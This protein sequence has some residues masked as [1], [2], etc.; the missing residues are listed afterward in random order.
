MT[1]PTPEQIEA[2]YQA[3]LNFPHKRG[4][5][6]AEDAIRA[7]LVAAGA[8]PRAEYHRGYQEGL[9]QAGMAMQASIDAGELVPADGDAPQVGEDI[10]ALID[11]ARALAAR[12]VEDSADAEALQ[13]MVGL[14]SDRLEQGFGR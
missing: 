6:N 2:A 11:E 12:K 9:L 4:P 10:S 14:L 5:R 3:W 13:I 7:A 8:A 1:N